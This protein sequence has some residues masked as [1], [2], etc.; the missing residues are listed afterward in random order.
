MF[1]GYSNGQGLRITCT[2]K[3]P[4]RRSDYSLVLH[5]KLLFHLAISNMKNIST[6][7]FTITLI[8]SLALLFQFNIYAQDAPPVNSNYLIENGISPRVLDAAAS[9]YMQDGSFTEDVIIK[10]NKE[11]DKRE[12]NVILIYDP[13]Y[14][15]G[16]DIRIINKST[17]LS[18]KELKALKKY[19]EKS[20]FLSRMSEQYLY[21]ETS[22]RTI[23]NDGNNIVLEFY[24]KKKDIEP[25]LKYIKRIKGEIYISNGNLKKVV[26]TN[27]KPLQNNIVDY[28]KEVYFVKAKEG[29][30]IISSVS[31]K[32]VAEKSGKKEVVE[33]ITNILDYKDP[34]GNSLSWENQKKT[35][36]EYDKEN[37]ITVG[38]GGTLP[39]L[40]KEATKMGYKLPRPVGLDV[41]VYAHDQQMDFTALQVGFDGGNMVNLENL[42]ALKESSVSQSTFMPLAKADVWIFPF[43]N[44]M[45][46]VGGGQNRL[47]GELVINEDLRDFINGLPGFI[48]D[49]PNVPYAIPIKSNITSE[50][51]GGGATLAGGIA[52][53]NISVNYQLMFTKIVEAN[54]T[55]MVNVVTPMVGYMS[56]FGVN[57]MA[58]AQGQF[59]NTN[60]TGFIE[61]TDKDGNVHKLDYQVDFKPIQW[62]A[63]VGLYKSFAKHWEM[64]LQA[65]FGQRTSITAIF[66]YRF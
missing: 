51:Y 38:L 54:T 56:P 23:K 31:E 32:I 11:G 9:S 53:F 4:G 8:F 22:L 62:N 3:N 29:G 49:I 50:V 10:V 47:D 18:K 34:N 59:Y 15:D 33:I 6:K 14:N 39:F 21:D 48:I 58:G 63:I 57:F 17:K 64:S 24:Y 5:T 45:A 12:Y 36:I 28:S 30:Y 55:N 65:G 41:F 61:L 26:L 27:F 43:L 60:I 25:Y 2:R 66:G 1:A 37:L 40:G 42:F 13:F 52:D 35:T 7:K 44:V 19:I 46:I 20:H 16:M